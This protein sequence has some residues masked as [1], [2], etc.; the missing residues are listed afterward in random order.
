[1]ESYDTQKEA[2]DAGGELVFHYKRGSFRDKESSFHRDLASGK[3]FPQKGFMKALFAKKGNKITF[4][5][6]MAC[7]ALVLILAAFKEPA[8]ETSIVGVSAK[9]S[10]FL[11]DDSVYVK[12]EL[13][14]KDDEEDLFPVNL[15][16]C[17]ECMGQREQVEDRR[18]VFVIFDPSS[19][20]PVSAV[21]TDY[22]YT[23]VRCTLKSDDQTASLECK[24]K[25]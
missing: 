2:Q 21:F 18:D 1:M 24:V 4:A 23:L 12:L 11:F 14:P 25:R 19:P 17:I 5:S 7:A 13:T 6:M 9:I 16:V 8:D 22:G 10:S 20:K 3:S 15:D